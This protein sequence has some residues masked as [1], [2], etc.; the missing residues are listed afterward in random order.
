MRL[1]DRQRSEH[2]HD[3]R[4]EISLHPRLFRRLKL[5]GGPEGDPLLRQQRHQLRVPASVLIFDQR[6]DLAIDAAEL[7]AGREAVDAQSGALGIGLLHDPGH[8]DL[9]KLVEVGTHDREELHALEQ[10]VVRT[11][12]LLQHAPVKR[13]PALLAVAVDRPAGGGRRG[14]PGGGF[15]RSGSA[16][17]RNG[18]Q[19]GFSFHAVTRR[20][21]TRG[22]ERGQAPCP[23]ERIA[24]PSRNCHITLAL[25]ARTA[26]GS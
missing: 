18:R 13:Q 7:F 15:R 10:R 23:D 20:A 5:G 22:N 9:E 25:P 3:L 24:R 17:G 11:A 1:V 19:A 21:S 12:R 6:V 14:G 8:P 4:L 2:R 26:T 16:G